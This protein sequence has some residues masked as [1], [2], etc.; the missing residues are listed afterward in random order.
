MECLPWCK[1]LFFTGWTSSASG[2]HLIKNGF[3]RTSRWS[4]IEDIDGSKRRYIYHL[5]HGVCVCLIWFWF[6][7]IYK[8]RADTRQTTKVKLVQYIS[9]LDNIS[10]T[11]AYVTGAFIAILNIRCSFVT[12]VSQSKLPAIW[13]N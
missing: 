5:P 13:V 2:A 9:L 8:T 3:A 10:S 7:C 11:L 6:F 1:S 4:A 12:L